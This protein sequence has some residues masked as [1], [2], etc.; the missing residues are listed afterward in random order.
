[1]AVATVPDT[2]W[3]VC[4][5]ASESELNAG[6]VRQRTI[7]LLVGAF[8]LV[9]V[10]T[11]ITLFNRRVVLSPLAAI[12]DFTN[13]VAS[14]DLKASLRG[15]FHFELA[16]LAVNLER[17]VGELKTK[18]GFSEGVLHGIPAPCAVINP[19]HK[20]T[21]VNR[22]AYDSLEKPYSPDGHKGI[23][24]GE[25][26]FGDATRPTLSDKALA[27]KKT[28]TTDIEYRT[29]QNNLRHFTIT[30]TPFFDMDGNMLGSFAFW[31]DL[32]E[33]RTQQKRIEEQSAVIARTA[34]EASAV[35]DR[36]ASAAQELSAQIEQSTTGAETQRE[37]IQDTATAVEEMNATIIEVAKNSAQTATNAAAAKNKA[38]EG[39]KLVDEVVAAVLSVQDESE[40]LKAN[41]HDL[42]EKAQGI[43]AILGVISDI[44]DQTNLLALNAAIE[45][46]RA[47]DAGRGF[48]VVADE[49]RKLAEKTMAATK[50]V[51]QAIAGIQQGT[52]ETVVKMEGAVA[53]VGRATGLAKRSGG[54]LG[55]IVSLVENAGDQVS[56]IATAA[57]QQ[58]ATA[59]EINRTVDE[60][61]RLAAETS[62]AMAQSNQAVIELAELAQRL[63]SLI[64]DLE[65]G[66]AGPKALT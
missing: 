49:V 30:A 57:E 52:R 2:G 60:V 35:A 29:P 13:K 47:G 14:G 25:F 4:M 7:L 31:T 59:E 19:D 28:C 27:E 10:V 5:T 44:A 51:G 20:I 42:G 16:G 46:A 63:N 9:T 53:A 33:I 66:V 54:T 38:N 61:N 1:M 23:S 58:S 37:R 26:F 11:T 32:T 65:G 17:M 62:E 41:M 56:S 39:A 64:Q 6:A 36:M 34:A 24:V 22:P 40:T 15:R 18:L 45:A 48:A 3:V 43:G 50:E 55:E 8:V 21:W 12:S